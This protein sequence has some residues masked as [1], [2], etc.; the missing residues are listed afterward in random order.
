[1]AFFKS[2]I[3]QGVT[4][5]L[6]HLDPFSFSI[7]VEGKARIV[8]ERFSPHCFTESL[9]PRH[10]LDLRYTHKNE[11]CAFNCDRHILSKLLPAIIVTLCNRTVIC[12]KPVIISC[13][14][15]IPLLDLSVPIWCFSK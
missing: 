8:A 14:A 4:C 9:T 3:I 13:C 2:K 10:S 7:V 5:A 1:M 6:D 12:P 15:R 11:T